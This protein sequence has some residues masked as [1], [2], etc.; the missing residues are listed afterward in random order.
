MQ[1]NIN[2][3]RFKTD[4]ELEKFIVNK[5]EK[6]GKL[7]EKVIG[8][9]V[10]LKLEN[11]EKPENKIAEIRLKIKGNDLISSK[12]CKTFEEATDL[13][14]E[15]LRRQLKKVK[16]KKTSKIVNKNKLEKIKTTEDT[17]TDDIIEDIE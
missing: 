16:D 1:V 6:V 4:K 8:S 15:A 13:A 3:V 7:H 2:A 11:T 10:T 9:D 14:I 5:L 12:Q 17:I